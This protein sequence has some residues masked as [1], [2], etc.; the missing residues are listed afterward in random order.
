MADGFASGIGDGDE[1]PAGD[2]CFGDGLGF[3]DANPWLR[4]DRGEVGSGGL[5]LGVVGG[6]GDLNHVDSRELVR[7]GGFARTGLEIGH[8]FDDVG[9]RE[10]GETGVLGAAL[11]IGK[12]TVA[13]GEDCGLAASGNDRR[14]RRMAVGMPVRDLEEVLGLHEGEGC[15]AVGNVQQ[16]GIR[17]RILV[18]RCGG[19][20]GRVESVG[21]VGSVLV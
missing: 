20:G 1:H 7:L 19:R 12:M 3:D 13:A 17:W 15:G 5:N 21:P 14:H 18:G 16:R 6:L 2:V 11:T 8:L 4:F 10:T 9:G